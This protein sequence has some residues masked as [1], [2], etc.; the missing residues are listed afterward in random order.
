MADWP[1][2]LVGHAASELTARRLIAQ[3]RACEAAALAFCRLLERWGR[4]EA[5]PADRRRARGRAPPR[6]RPRRDGARRAR[7]AARPLP[8]RARGRPGRGPLVVHRPGR[9][10]ARRVEGRA[11]RAPACRPARTASPPPISSWRCSCARSRASPTPR[12]STRRRTRRRSGRASST[13]ATRCSARPWTTCGR[14]PPELVL[15]E[16]K[17]PTRTVPCSKAAC[18]TGTQSL[19]SALDHRRRQRQPRPRR[20]GRAAAAAGGD[21]HGRGFDRVPGGKGANQAVACA[22]LGADVT[23]VCAVGD[24]AFADEALPQE[25]RLD[26]QAARGST[27]RPGVALILVDAAGENQIAVAPGA[28]AEVGG[29][30]LARERRGPLPARD[31]G[32]RGRQRLG[33][34]D[35]ALLPERR[36]GAADRRRRRPRPSSTATS[37]RC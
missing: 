7:G 33:A 15:Q 20:A 4:G 26:V 19:V 2:I 11:R 29:F 28:N 27:R 13:S 5:K 30:E 1:D 3:L 36:A 23:L 17:L 31:P 34:G 24:D 37:S 10:R 8:A 35:R 14:S 6:R 16:H 22:R 9:R 21:G 32:R 12:G 18:V 25:E